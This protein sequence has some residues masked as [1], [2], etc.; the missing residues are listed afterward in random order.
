MKS[1]ARPSFF[2]VFDVLVS[3]TNPGLKL[4]RWTH[5]GIEFE[6]ERHSFSGPRHSLTVEITTLTRAGRRGWSLM[7]T[8]EYWWAGTESKPF[9][10]LRWARPVSG[11]RGDILNWMRGQEGALDGSSSRAGNDSSNLDEAESSDEPLADE[12]AVKGEA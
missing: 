8:K 11:Q 1:F 6:R 10:S 2:R 5:A 7:V 4:T 9:K 3:T 12:N